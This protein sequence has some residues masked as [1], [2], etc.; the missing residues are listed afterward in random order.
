MGLADS[1]HLDQSNPRNPVNRR[2]SIV[3]LNAA[4]QRRFEHENSGDAAAEPISLRAPGKPQARAA[5][6]V[7]ALQVSRNP[8]PGPAPGRQ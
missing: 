4:T 6:R 7:A 8:T 2:I 3:V 1:A 5:P